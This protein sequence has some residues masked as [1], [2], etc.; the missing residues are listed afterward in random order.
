MRR[1]AVVLATLVALVAASPAVAAA[2]GAV[3]YRPP[4]DAPVVDPFRPADPNWNSG[5]RGLE[6]ATTPGT[7]VGAAAAG[8]VVFAGPVADGLHVVVLH[9]D[10][11]RTSYSFLALV[12]V[13]RGDRVVQG[14]TVG[15]TRDRF[16]F[17]VRAGEAYLDP[18]RL[19]GGGP[20]QVYLVPERHRKP[21]S[22]AE[23]RGGI[24]RMFQG[25]ASQAID[26]AEDGIRWAAGQAVER[27][28]D[29]VDEARGAIH[30]ALENR[31]G[32]GLRDFLS[33]AYEWWQARDD[34]TPESV[35]QPRLQERH[36]LVTVAG[37]GST[38]DK[39]AIDK[40]DA[41]ALG[42]APGDVVR[43]SYLGGTITENPYKGS[44]TT[45]DIRTSGRRLRELLARI[46]AE[47]PG[48]PIDIVAH[49][50]GGIVARSALTDEGE[51]TDP[52]LPPISSFV[53]LASPHQGAPL[54]TAATMVGHT[55]TGELVFAGVH[56]T[57][58]D[59]FDPAGTSVTQMAEHSEFM[60]RLNSRPLP[61]GI[62]ATSIGAR[63]DLTVPAPVTHLDGAH[64]VTVSAPGHVRDHSALPGSDQAEREIALAVAGMPP[65]CQGFIDTMADVGV[66]EFIYSVETKAGFHA[67]L[68]A[69][70]AD[71]WVDDHT[72]ITVP[73]RYDDHVPTPSP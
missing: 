59:D 34:C 66:S 21:L 71:R 5:N 41:A 29:A 72:K 24:V 10:G 65:T 69:H 73:R 38:S 4:V 61:A 53:T 58:P 28:D 56:A 51:P 1:L 45:T 54:A 48:V 43:F 63:E 7:T 11:L 55:D 67:W 23:E 60:E 6:Y 37:L 36:I 20:P 12:A 9:D 18:A 26:A 40:V 49:S 35:A 16:H 27:F 3:T 64:N 46:A 57:T 50:Q 8:E 70:A 13:R 32:P 33:A 42:Y 39:G 25:L 22:E 47:N 31:P 62:R 52:R 17:G 19:F 30:Y 14:Q 44:D 68:A 2:P 15:T